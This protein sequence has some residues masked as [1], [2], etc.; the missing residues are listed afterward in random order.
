MSAYCQGMF[1]IASTSEEI[2]TGNTPDLVY[3]SPHKTE[4][5]KLK[6]ISYIQAENIC[7]SS[8]CGNALW[9]KNEE[10]PSIFITVK[11]NANKQNAPN[12]R[13]PFHSAFHFPQYS[14]SPLIGTPFCQRIL[15]LL[16]RCPL[17]RGS[18]TCITHCQEFVSFPEGC[19]L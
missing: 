13:I 4:Y 7:L 17:V 10:Y 5:H 11:T 18:I 12:I 15:A 6:Y 3:L 9:P 16:E 14:S 1:T 19:P 2:N 8:W